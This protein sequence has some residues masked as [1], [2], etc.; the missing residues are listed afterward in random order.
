MSFSPTFHFEFIIVYGVRECSSFICLHV[1][2]RFSQHHLMNGL[3]FNP[4][5]ILASFVID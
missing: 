1:S 2:V 5:L 4:L 3:F